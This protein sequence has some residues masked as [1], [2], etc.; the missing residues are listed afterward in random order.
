MTAVLSGCY[1]A[2]PVQKQ[3]SVVPDEIMVSARRAPK[4]LT[5]GLTRPM[6]LKLSILDYTS[7]GCPADPASAMHQNTRDEGEAQIGNTVNVF[8]C[9]GFNQLSSES[10]SIVLCTGSCSLSV[11]TSSS[12]DGLGLPSIDLR[13]RSIVQSAFIQSS[14]LRRAKHTCCMA[15][16]RL[17]WRCSSGCGTVS[18]SCGLLWR[19]GPPLGACRRRRR[20]MRAR[21]A[22]SGRYFRRRWSAGFPCLHSLQRVRMLLNV[23]VKVMLLV[24]HP[25]CSH[26]RPSLSATCS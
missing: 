1:Q 8:S 15:C 25:S 13:L 26:C 20:S 24:V 11:R 12:C 16:R 3:A 19:W 4:A 2:R 21:R 6:K 23:R 14:Y 5:F 10:P 18:P 7:E 9:N 22:Q 17:S